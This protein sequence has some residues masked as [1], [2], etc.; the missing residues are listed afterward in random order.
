MEP[1]KGPRPGNGGAVLVLD[2]I[3]KVEGWPEA[4]KL[5]WD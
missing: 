4:V 5:L 3:Q 2:E 1:D